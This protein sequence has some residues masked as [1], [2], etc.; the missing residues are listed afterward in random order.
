MSPTPRRSRLRLLL[1][2][3]LGLALV[4]AFVLALDDPAKALATIRGL[5]PRLIALGLAAYAITYA[6]R[7]VR[8]RLLLSVRPPPLDLF[9]VMGVHNLFNML[10]PARTGELSYVWL[11]HRRW[12][13]PLPE[14]TASLLLARVYDMAGIGLFFCAALLAATAER[15]SV[16]FAGCA[17]VLA[18]I[19]AIVALVPLTKLFAAVVRRVLRS[20]SDG[21]RVGRMLAALDRMVD[22]FAQMNRRRTA[23]WVFLVT[24]AQWL[25]TFATCYAILRACPGVGAFPFTA[26]ILGSTGL[27]VA[28]ILPINPVGNVGT[29]QAGWIAGYM[30]AGM[31]RDLA[32]ATSLAAHVAILA[33]AVV[34]GLLGR[35]WL[36]KPAIAGVADLPATREGEAG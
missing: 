23:A 4:A 8:F 9:A 7:A 32:I 14:A 24:E 27:S 10:L 6:F 19:A 33:F 1:T 30:L 29:F 26:S 16:L 20:R 34:L 12:G 15:G 11:A 13:A 22:S 3:A 31:D 17:L 2:L 28:L 21:P 5:D 35:M 18:S 36:R 25:A